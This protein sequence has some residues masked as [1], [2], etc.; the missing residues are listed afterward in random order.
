MPSLNKSLSEVNKEIKNV[1]LSF[2]A[3]DS[4]Q[5]ASE[6]GSVVGGMTDVATGA[7]LALGVAEDSAQEFFNTLAQVEGTGRIV[8]GS[9]EGIQ[10]ASKLYNNVIKQG[11]LLQQANAATL[12]A[13]G[14]AQKAYTAAIGTST[15]GLKL[16]R[17]ALIGTGI[18]AIVVGIGLLIANFDKI[19]DSISGAIDNFDGIGRGYAIYFIAGKNIN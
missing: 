10:S 15:G 12:G 9:I 7:F 16:F 11:N 5:V 3:L 6:V 17:L 14:V 1:E 4:E 19:R 2:E 13:V 18:G 8:K